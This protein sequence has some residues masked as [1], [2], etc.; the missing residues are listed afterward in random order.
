MGE[1]EST[2]DCGR[3]LAKKTVSSTDL[4]TLSLSCLF[5]HDSSGGS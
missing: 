3:E 4:G 1:Q 2:S 5:N